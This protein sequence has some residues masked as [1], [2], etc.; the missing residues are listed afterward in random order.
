MITRAQLIA[1]MP[2]A[3]SRVD[4][5]LEPLNLA[6]AEYGIDTQRRVSAFLAQIAHESGQ[7]RYVRELASG[8]A[9]DTGR[10]AAR[11]GNTPE[12]DG[13]GQRY[14]GRG[15]IQ[16]TGHDNYRE[17]SLALYGDPMTLLRNPEM[18]EDPVAAARSAAWF[19]WSRGLNVVADCPNSFQT[20]TRRINGGLNGYEERV[21]YFE[22]A[23][24]VFA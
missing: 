5:W 22:R 6:M 8:E 16:I 24:R 11:L 20:I 14:K 17:C 13:D 4:C 21:A 7:L 23:Q 15:L 3:T 19:W 18:L 9:Y 1:V 12:A 10:L 2:L